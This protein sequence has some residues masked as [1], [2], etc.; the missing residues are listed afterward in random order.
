[1]K[2]LLQPRRSQ[3]HRIRNT[4]KIIEHLEDTLPGIKRDGRL[5]LANMNDRKLKKAQV[6]FL[7]EGERSREP[8]GWVRK[9][10]R[11]H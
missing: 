10:I 6:N 2:G 5:T 11:G 8:A 7:N 1:M 4:F 3:T 9:H